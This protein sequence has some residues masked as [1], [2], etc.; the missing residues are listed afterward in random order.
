[1]NLGD[2]IYDNIDENKYLN[3]IYDCILYNYSLSLLNIEL[4]PREFNL[5]DALRFADLLSKSI[6]D[7]NAEKHKIWGQEIVALLKHLNPTDNGVE[8]Y[9]GSIL[10]TTGNYRGRSIK[11]PNFENPSLLNMLYDEFS[12]DYFGIPADNSKQ[13]FRSQKQVYDHLNDQYFSFSG[14]TSMGK[15]FVMRMFI[16]EQ[17]V[18]AD[19]KNFAV[20]VPTKALINEVSSSIIKELDKLLVNKNY[21]VITSAG[22]LFLEQEHNFIYVLTP[23]R[24]L[25]LLI[26]H[27]DHPIDWLFIDEAHKISAKDS[28]SAFYYKVVDMLLQRERKPNIIFASPNIPN[29]DIFLG[30]IPD[31]DK[32]DRK[33]AS[34]YS[35]VSQIKYLLDFVDNKFSFYNEHIK[36]LQTIEINAMLNFLS[37]L[38]IFYESEKS[39]IVY[40]NSKDKAME[41]AKDFARDLPYLEDKDLRVLSN[42]IKTG[43][44]KDFFLADMVLKGVAFHIGYLPSTIRAKIEELY[45][46]RKIRIMFCTSTLIEG[47]NLPADNLFITTYK[48]GNSILSPVDFRNLIGRVGRIEYNL[49]GNVFLTRL[50]EYNTTQKGFIDILKKEVPEQTLSLVAELTKEHKEL[51]IQSLVDGNIEIPRVDLNGEKIKDTPYGLI[52]K[53]ALILLRDI[54]NN[55]N[56]VVRKAFAEV[57]TVEQE[58]TIKAKFN[59]MESKPDDDINASVDQT[60]RLRQAIKDGLEYPKIDEIKGYA[61]HKDIVEFL[62]KLYDI[63]KWDKYES[64]EISNKNSLSWYAT[65]LGQWINGYGLS[66]IASKSIE[67]AFDSM[68]TRYPKTVGV[69]GKWVSYNNSAFHKNLV[70]GEVLQA[71]ESVILFSFANY[72]LKFSEC[73]KEIKG[74]DGVMANDWYDFVEYGTTNTLSIFLQRNGFSRETSLYIKDN[75]TK[76]VVIIDGIPKLLKS[77][78]DEAKE[79]IQ[80]EITEVMLNAP[81]LFEE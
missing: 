58:T 25:Y 26:R 42:E 7:K 15:S 52:R 39:T 12:K 54:T 38:N 67:F 28:R 2:T 20:I 65:I 60:N 79:S 50:P 32:E 11:T 72:F 3:E 21:R 45:R 31:I 77:I 18:S 29:P 70:I 17:V 48:R 71:I 46:S 1:M 66:F 27:K 76:F 73:Y 62:G 8:H 19:P 59:E 43:I 55:R 36:E 56:S 5:D 63:F 74:I 68:Q 22:S 6:H 14:P 81:E 10:T 16:K 13:F 61:E 64:K 34:S 53:F 4:T 44:H 80:D 30:L 57:L 24:L 9:L 40:I 23:E 41:Q 69:N 78:I 35:P 37:I 75:K 49:Y 51:I 47:V 33:L